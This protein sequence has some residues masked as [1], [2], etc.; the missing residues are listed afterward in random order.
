MGSATQASHSKLDVT[1]RGEAV[2][3]VR[4]PSSSYY[5]QNPFEAT[6]T[7]L[8]K[9]KRLR[10]ISKELDE[11]TN[12]IRLE[13]NSLEKAGLLASKTNGRCREIQSSQAWMK[14]KW[15]TLKVNTIK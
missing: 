9:P 10:A 5:L 6:Q 7:L 13:L 4:I 12:S 2:K 11:N 8:P 3:K 14:F 1:H 15:L